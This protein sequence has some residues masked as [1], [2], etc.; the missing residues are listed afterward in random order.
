MVWGE[1]P[2]FKETPIWKSVNSDI[3][4]L[5]YLRDFVWVLSLDFPRIG[6]CGHFF[7]ALE[8][9]H[10]VVIIHNFCTGY[11]IW[12]YHVVSLLTNAAPCMSCIIIVNV[13]TKKWPLHARNAGTVNAYRY[14]IHISRGTREGCRLQKS[15]ITTAGV[16]SR[17][18]AAAKCLLWLQG[19]SCL[20]FPQ[21]FWYTLLEQMNKSSWQGWKTAQI[22]S[23]SILWFTF[24]VLCFVLQWLQP[25][26]QVIKMLPIQ[27]LHSLISGQITQTLSCSW[28]DVILLIWVLNHHWSSNSHT[29]KKKT[30]F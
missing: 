4:Y 27:T 20:V 30:T 6:S 23:I 3:R 11:I 18:T 22:Q 19:G 7:S 15:G 5:S 12:I 14:T 21:N 25:T 9:Q 8:Q 13:D 24:F 10:L 29:L 17:H 1:N 26:T 28:K 16:V 2:P